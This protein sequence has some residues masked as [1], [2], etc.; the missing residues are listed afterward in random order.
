M[1]NFNHATAACQSL[2]VPLRP[3]WNLGAK[4]KHW[5]LFKTED[6]FESLK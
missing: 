5:K 4:P 2:V 6:E 1:T 3:S